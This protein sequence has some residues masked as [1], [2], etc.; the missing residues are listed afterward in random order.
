[1][2]LTIG[3]RVFMTGGT[4]FCSTQVLA[5]LT[6][7]LA[8]FAQILAAFAHVADLALAQLLLLNPVVANL[9]ALLEAPGII[10]GSLRSLLANEPVRLRREIR[11]RLA[12][13]RARRR[14]P[15]WTRRTRILAC[16]LAFRPRLLALGLGRPLVG[17]II[18]GEGRA[19]GHGRQ[20]QGKENLTHDF[21][22]SSSSLA[23]K[24]RLAS[25][26]AA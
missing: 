26:A 12:V 6:E 15:L 18:L 16:R 7:V 21:D 8:L 22:L 1:M 9:L 19:C 24:L 13:V 10:V 4:R 3:G 20:E 17:V 14:L 2:W 25:L 5:L 11:R 23:V